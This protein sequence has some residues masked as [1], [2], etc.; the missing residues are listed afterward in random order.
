MSRANGSGP[1]PERRDELMEGEAGGLSQS[2]ISGELSGTRCGAGVRAA[3]EQLGGSSPGTA[4]RGEGPGPAR[5]PGVRGGPRRAP[6]LCKAEK[7]LLG[8]SSR[9]P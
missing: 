8:L 3:T 5:S 4:G 9:G 6:Y 2:C 7:R 1:D